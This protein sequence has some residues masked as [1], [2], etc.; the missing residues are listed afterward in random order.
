[1]T[2]ANGFR[3]VPSRLNIQACVRLVAAPVGRYTW[4]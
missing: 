2:R 1:M 4:Q 3:F